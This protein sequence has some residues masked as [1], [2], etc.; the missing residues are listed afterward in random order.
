MANAMLPILPSIAKPSPSSLQ[1]KS[2]PAYLRYLRGGHVVLRLSFIAFLFA[3]RFAIAVDPPTMTVEETKTLSNVARQLILKFLPDPALTTKKNWGNQKEVVVRIDGERK[4]PFQWKFE[5]KKELKNDGH[6]RA[7]TLSAVEPAT[8]FGIELKDIVTPEPGKTTFT[9][10]LTSPV[11]FEF[12]QQ[13]W[14]A[15]IRLLRGETRGRCDT[16]IVLR[17]ESMSKLDW[18]PGK[19]LPSQILRVKVTNADVNYENLKIEHTAGLGGDA[20]KVVG[21]TVLKAVKL[22]KPNLEK[23]LLEK[24][25]AAIVKAGDSKEMKL[26]LEKLIGGKK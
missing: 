13:F 21:E 14:K 9:A 18:A 5:T 1:A 19:L 8:K 20:A 16:T 24:A 23:D 4:G 15:G 11:K 26:D 7:L 25:N 10:I 3:S 6:W 2:F 12:E 17:C 22:M